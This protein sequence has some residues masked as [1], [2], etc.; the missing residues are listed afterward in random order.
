MLKRNDDINTREILS[1][2]LDTLP[3]DSSVTLCKFDAGDYIAGTIGTI[4]DDPLPLP[5]TLPSPLQCRV[6]RGD[7]YSNHYLRIPVTRDLVTLLHYA[8]ISFDL[9]DG[10]IFT[11]A[12]SL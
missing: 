12:E 11:S 7:D 2:L 5:F 4:A 8:D 10:W 9:D 1:W 3:H 6:Y